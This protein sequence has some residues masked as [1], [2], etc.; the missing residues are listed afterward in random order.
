MAAG[1]QVRPRAA[2]FH[3]SVSVARAEDLLLLCQLLQASQPFVM[4]REEVWLLYVCWYSR[5]KISK[6][7]GLRYCAALAIVYFC[8][9]VYRHNEDA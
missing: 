7:R 9:L 6:S 4:G 1:A 5:I 2:G 3:I 8:G